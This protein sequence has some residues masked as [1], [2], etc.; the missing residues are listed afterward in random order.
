MTRPEHAFYERTAE[1]LEAGR[2]FV[3]CR[4]VGAVGS[5]PRNAGAQMLVFPEGD[6]EFTLGGGALEGRVIREAVLAGPE[7]PPRVQAYHLGDL[8]MHCGGI[9]HV[10]FEPA[11]P[12]DL[13][14]YRRA[15]ALCA[16]RVPFWAVYGLEGEAPLPKALFPE[17]KAPWGPDAFL[18]R[19]G[20]A[21]RA[22]E[23]EDGRAASR[24]DVFVQRVLPPLRLLIFGAGH[25]GA[26][27][28]EVAA[29]TGIFTVEVV[30]DRPAFA[31]PEKLSG[32][33]TVHLAP[34]NYAG[35][36]PLPDA[37][38]FVAVITRCHATDQAV[39]RTLI[40]SGRPCAYL[41]MI[42]SVPKRVKLFKQLADEGLPRQ[43]LEAVFSPMGLPIGGKSPG[44]IAISIL[45]EMIR[46]KNALEGTL[47]GG[48]T[49]WQQRV[50]TAR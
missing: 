38:T 8:G 7:G 23:A 1:L 22:L 37:R 41:G 12:E 40:R 11:R 24:E 39:V 44:E 50:A 43:A 30:D 10:A 2:A 36:L 29:A 6:I 4:V 48:L 32:A 49:R 16:R 26:K 17:G 25:V 21:V 33:E 20:Q 28:A 31:D 46:Q 45:A 47:E 42:G 15:A 9:V 27:L 35:E 18:S 5:A 34:E 3:V 14:F 19:A 13:P